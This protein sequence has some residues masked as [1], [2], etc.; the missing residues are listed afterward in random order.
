MRERF[1][2]RQVQRSAPA[3]CATRAREHVGRGRARARV[4]TRAV[5]APRSHSHSVCACL[6]GRR[7]RTLGA[8]GGE[9]ELTGARRTQDACLACAATA[10]VPALCGTARGT[11]RGV[12]SS[13]ILPGRHARHARPD[14]P[15]LVV[16]PHA[17]AVAAAARSCDR[18]V[19]R[20]GTLPVVDTQGRGGAGKACTDTAAGAGAPR[21]LVSQLRCMPDTR[22]PPGES[23]R[24]KSADAEVAVEYTRMPRSAHAPTR[25]H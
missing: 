10:M 21:G 2:T 5:T 7:P 4:S 25:P 1:C 8:I 19:G 6:A 9:S 23:A 24:A 11:Y 17:C 14:T 18:T 3:Q 15:R 16:R 22:C 12:L 20:A 13:L